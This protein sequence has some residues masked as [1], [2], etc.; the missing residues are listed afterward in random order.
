MQTTLLIDNKK[1]I[2]K[3]YKKMKKLLFLA[4]IILLASCS[5][6]ISTKLANE[7]YPKLNDENQIIVLEKEDVL[8]S[9]SEFIGDIKIGDSGFTMNCGYD[10]VIAD[11]TTAA[12]S[13]GANLVQLIEV[14]EPSL[15]G[16]SCY[17]IKA[18]I[19]RNLNPESLSSIVAKRNLRN[20]SRL[21]E[22]SDYALVHFYRPSLGAGALLGY[23]IKDS[24]DSIVG[25]LRNGEK[26]AYKIKKTG[27][28]SFY[29]T[30]ETKEEIKINI[31]K[32]KE[33]FVRCSINMG[34]VLGRPEINL[35][36]NYIGMKEY[37]A[38]K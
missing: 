4:T 15:L 24:N 31:E 9:N 27:T 6:S 23:K 14:K 8:P 26:F 16:S 38:M 7:N 2:L 30:L 12:R 20:N 19:Y 13:A 18:K 35:I 25:R 34:I 3:P 1:T 22:D 21:P 11:A 33:Y 10:K 17:R 36:E 37:D 29:G 5:A 28:Q 32:G